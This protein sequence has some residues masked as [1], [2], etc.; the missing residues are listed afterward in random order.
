MSEKGDYLGFLRSKIDDKVLFIDDV[1]ASGI[2]EWR[3]EI[4]MDIVNYRYDLQCPTVFTSNLSKNEISAGYGERV[5]SRLFSKENVI[6]EMMSATDLR[7]Q[8]VEGWT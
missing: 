1:G 6:I 2:T 4:L 3:K 7:Q 8:E 5:A